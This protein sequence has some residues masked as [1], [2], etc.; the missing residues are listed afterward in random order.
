MSQEMQKFA[1][2]DIGR[3][4]YDYAA[5]AR[6][7][8]QYNR[9]EHEDRAEK[10]ALLKQIFAQA[11]EVTFQGSL[12]IVRGKL[13][14]IGRKVFIN[15]G[16]ELAGAATITIGHHTLIGPHVQIQTATHPVDPT[17]RQ[18]WA[19]WAKP[20]V[21]GQNVWIGASAIICPGVTIGDHSVIGAGSVVTRDVP[22]C[23]LAVGN[24]AQV[25]RELTPPDEAT[26]YAK[27]P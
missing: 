19:F 17:E 12:N 7:I 3:G 25:I 27:N 13:I 18:Q 24:P 8:A 22:P 1:F 11:D 2:E 15:Y 6:L 14:S 5:E 23:S 21:I 10:A 26:L 9:L 4:S 16:V 20:I